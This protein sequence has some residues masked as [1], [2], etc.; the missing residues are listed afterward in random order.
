M[1]QHIGKVRWGIAGLLGTG[2]VINYLDHVNISVATQPLEQQFHLYGGFHWFCP[3]DGELLNAQ[4][5]CHICGKH[6]RDLFV[7]LVELHPHL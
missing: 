4:L 6:I 1:Q 3:G 7:L 5:E 2:I